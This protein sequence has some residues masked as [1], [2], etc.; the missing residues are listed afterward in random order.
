MLQILIFI[1]AIELDLLKK[2]QKNDISGISGSLQLI[3]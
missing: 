1:D 3:G 2:L